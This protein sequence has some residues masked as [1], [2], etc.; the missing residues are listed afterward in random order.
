MSPDP[1]PSPEPPTPRPAYRPA[2]PRQPP[3][4]PPRRGS[5]LEVAFV[6]S[7]LL[8]L[9]LIAGGGLIV[10]LALAAGMSGSDGTV[11]EKFYGGKNTASDKIAVIKIDGVIL[12]GL[13]NHVYKEIDTAA[14]DKAVKAVVLRIDSPGGSITASDDLYKRLVELRDGNPIKKTDGKKHLVV[15]M[16]GLAASGGYYI[17]MPG[18]PLFGERTTMTGSIGVYSAF[19]NVAKLAQKY[20]VEMDIIKR[21][22][23][24]ASGSL[25]KEMTPEER[26]V[27]QD[28]VDAA[29]EQFKHVVEE[30][31][32]QL[33][34]K[35]EEYV[36]QRPM[37]TK[38]A[39]GKETTFTYRRQRV[40][41]GIFTAD[42]AVKF[43]LIDKV[44]YLDDAIAEAKQAAGLGDDYKV[45]TYEKLFSLQD[46][47][48]G[49]ETSERAGSQVDLKKLASGVSPRLWYLAPNSDLAGILAAAS[50]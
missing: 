49:G 44:G 25:F 28:S 6:L 47:F 8:N 20:G 26:Q 38:D 11:Q 17:A 40:D 15:S 13:L 10:L 23:V 29:Y 50:R 43:G 3:P 39:D 32:P 1:V 7:I 19:P 16:G 12:E 42:E 24:K 33:K 30:G 22:A 34:G 36:I 27:W 37:K 5:C 41:G 31:R 2:P 14:Q 48:L 9:F 46:V 18:N 45:V 35:L 21:G 4:P